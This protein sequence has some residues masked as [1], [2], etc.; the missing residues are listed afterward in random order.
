MNQTMRLF[1]INPEREVVDLPDGV[2]HGTWA[3]YKS[4]RCRCVTC[5][6]WV[7]RRQVLSN[8]MRQYRMTSEQIDAYEAATRCSLCGRRF[9]VSPRSLSKVIDHCHSTYKIRG[10]L[11]NGCNLR[12]GQGDLT[13][14]EMFV[15]L[16]N[17]GDWRAAAYFQFSVVH[18]DGT[19]LPIWA[20]SGPKETA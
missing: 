3:S 16:F 10:F 20:T 11:H 14:D 17:L 18:P 15:A 5:T 6:D 2:S 13:D 19:H 1:S 9:L 4:Y 7:V 8:R 12:I